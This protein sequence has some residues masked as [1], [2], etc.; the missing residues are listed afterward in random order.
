MASDT[1]VRRTAS[2][3]MTPNELRIGNYVR[4]KD[5][6]NF[7]RVSGINRHSVYFKHLFEND[8]Y[9]S[10]SDIE[11]I[12]IREVK[13]SLPTIPDLIWADKTM[14]EDLYYYRGMVITDLHELQNIYYALTGEELKIEL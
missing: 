2:Q 9:R 8:T 6:G 7:A 3:T 5:T 11:P 13:D 1:S 10:Y 12:L 4:I 14:C